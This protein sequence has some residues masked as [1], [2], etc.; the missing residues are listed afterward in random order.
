MSEKVV[1]TDRALKALRPSPAGKRRVTWD[2]VQPHLGIRVTGTGAKSFVVVKRITGVR[3]P[4]VHVLG[5]YPAVALADARQRA[6]TILSQIAEGVDP[7]TREAAQE[8]ERRQRDKDTFSAVA[9]AFVAK[10]ASKNRSGAETKRI[11]DLYLIPT[12][13][14][15]QIGAIK[16]RKIAELLDEIE[17]R[18]FTGKGGRKLGGPVMA[19]HVL[20]ALRKLMNW[21]AA[22][23]D[24]FVSPIVKGMARTKSKD[25]ARDRVLTDEEIRA[26]WVATE[27]VSDAML[28]DEREATNLYSAL[29]RVLLLTAQRR[30]EGAQMTRSGIG[31]G[32]NWMIPAEHDKNKILR[33]VPLT[34]S[35]LEIIDGVD[36]VNECDLVFTTNGLTPFSGFNKAKARLDGAMLRRLKEAAI[37]YSTLNTLEY[38]VFWLRRARRG[39]REARAT[40]KREWWTLHDLRRT[41]KTLMSRAGVRPDISERVLGHII[42]GVEGVYDRYEYIAEKRRALGALASLVGQIVTQ[43]PPSALAESTSE[44]AVEYAAN[45]HSAEVIAPGV[46]P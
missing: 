8:A 41:A 42:G 45:A 7:K 33:L 1:L 34:S 43:A 30:E 44:Q 32:N 26:F 37:D 25:R 10:H 46:N 18:R 28:A 35:V 23:D 15:Q 36:I 6:R 40:L 11:I 12:F 22:R 17:E 13:G 16:R 20:A 2:A 14:E 5:G 29:V 39:D 27:K 38:F 9:T 24:D 31:D 4:I 19:D 21:H 3:A